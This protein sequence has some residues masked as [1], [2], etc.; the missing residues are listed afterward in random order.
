MGITLEEM[1]EIFEG[2]LTEDGENPLGTRRVVSS[3]LSKSQ[4]SSERGMRWI[5]NFFGGKSKR[6][7]QAVPSTDE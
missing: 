1:D 4:T 2:S 5:L 3:Q 6:D 7:Y